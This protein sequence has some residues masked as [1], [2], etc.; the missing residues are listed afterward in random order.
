MGHFWRFFKSGAHWTDSESGIQILYFPGRM[1][2]MADL[3][4][5]KASKKSNRWQLK[6]FESLTHWVAEDLPLLEPAK[7]AE[8]LVF[9]ACSVFKTLVF[10]MDVAIVVELR[11]KFGTRISKFQRTWSWTE[12]RWNPFKC[13]W[14]SCKYKNL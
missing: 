10:V 5:C 2:R 4:S 13:C 1:G 12:I 9:L 6:F 11:S 7:L 3:G 8:Q 14:A